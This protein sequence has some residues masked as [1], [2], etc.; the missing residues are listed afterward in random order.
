M[1]QHLHFEEDSDDGL[2]NDY[3]QHEHNIYSEFMYSNEDQHQPS[4]GQWSASP[5]SPPAPFPPVH[6]APSSPGLGAPS[7]TGQQSQSPGQWSASSP[8]ASGVSP[9]SSATYTEPILYYELES[10]P[11]YRNPHEG[12]HD[13]YDGPH[14]GYENYADATLASKP[15]KLDQ[16]LYSEEHLGKF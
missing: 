10:E 12:D 16:E 15:A 6:R 1:F 4:P 9:I 14:T 5:P 8:G 3:N 7:S 11:E 13:I 2:Q